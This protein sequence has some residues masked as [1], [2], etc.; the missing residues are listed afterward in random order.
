MSAMYVYMEN[1]VVSLSCLCAWNK[2][3]ISVISVCI[4][5]G[6]IP[7]MYVC[8]EQ[9]SYL[10]RVCVHGT[11]VISLFCLCTCNNGLIPVMSVYME[12]RLY[13]CHACVHGITVI[14]MSCM[15]ARN[16]GY[17]CHVCVHGTKV[18]SLSCLCAWN[19]GHNSVMYEYT[20]QRS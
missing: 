3:R 15:S 6:C 17:I 12:Q 19:N 4:D 20:E 16:N 9:R 7:V 13:L 11:T 14:I 10:C 1:K 8:M 5:K 18:E 2:C